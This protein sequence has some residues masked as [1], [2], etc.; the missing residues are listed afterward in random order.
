[1]SDDR[2][3]YDVG[4]GKPPKHTRFKKGQSGNPKGR[5][6]GSRNFATDL[7]EVLSA[8]M[9]VNENG[10][11]K[12]VSSQLAA[13]MRLREKALKGDP[14]ALDRLLGLAADRSAEKEAQSTERSLSADETEILERHAEMVR[15]AAGIEE[16]LDG[17]AEEPDADRS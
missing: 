10:S 13:L 3:D 17:A 9:T 1:M 12:K 16:V 14:R 5:P 8:T 2:D 15:R 4:Y 6:K 7:D 11:P